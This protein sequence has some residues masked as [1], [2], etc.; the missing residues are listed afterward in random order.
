M[1]DPK[2]DRDYQEAIEKI[3]GSGQPA[4]TPAPS[5]DSE[6]ESAIQK[7]LAS[8]PPPE[9]AA[10]PETAAAPTPT[11]QLQG[12]PAEMLAPPQLTS[13]FGSDPAVSADLSGPYEALKGFLGAGA[14]RW[15]ESPTGRLVLGTLQ[16]A[17]EA[18]G[19]VGAP[20]I[21]EK[22]VNPF[23]SDPVQDTALIPDYVRGMMAD[24]SDPHAA[25]QQAVGDVGFSPGVVGAAEIGFDPLNALPLA[26]T[27]GIARKLGQAGRR[28]PAALGAVDE[29]LTPPSTAM[30]PSPAALQGEVIP[31]QGSFTEA[32]IDMMGPRAEPF[33]PQVTGDDMARILNTP[34][35]QSAPPALPPGQTIPIPLGPGRAAPVDDLDAAV[36]R[37]VG[38]APEAQ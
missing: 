30:A 11:P 12:A 1:P 23:L 27:P 29:V 31:P 6:F 7:I 8:A 20:M 38:D 13:P 2:R 18:G 21:Q 35:L 32:M 37:I 19:L 34:A 15:A 33:A 24:P 5:A 28:A 14:S 16:R 25:Y 3:L 10:P 26:A 22:L 36:Q 9:K 4:A 17:Q